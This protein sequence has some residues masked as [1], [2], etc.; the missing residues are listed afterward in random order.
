M[1]ACE[2]WVKFS[3]NHM[4]NICTFKLEFKEKQKSICLFIYEYFRSR[5]NLYSN[6]R[7]KNQIK[8]LAVLLLLVSKIFLQTI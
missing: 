5:V 7:F 2:K 4:N 6:L 1:I 8:I 3:S